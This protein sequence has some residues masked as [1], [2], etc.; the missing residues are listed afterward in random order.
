MKRIIAVL[1]LLASAWAA[2]VAQREVAAAET[3]HTITIDE[4]AWRKWGLQYPATYVFQVSDVP[5]QLAVLRR[6][7]ASQPWI[8]LSSKTGDEFFNG[9]EGVRVDRETKKVYASVG[10]KT[11]NTIELKF[12]GPQSVKF[13]AVAKYYDGRKA[14]YTLS[15]DNWGCNAWGH[16]G[17]PWKGETDDES[18]NYQAALHVCRSFHLP[19]SIAINSRSAGGDACWRLMQE[20]LDRGDASWEPA[21]H[22]WTHPKDAA[23]YAV[24]GYKQETVGCREDILQRLHN[25]PYGPYIV[26]HILTHGYQDDA[27]L[28]NDAGEFLFLRGFN[29]LDNPSSNEYVAW[30][31]QYGF[32]GVGGLNTR[33]YDSLLEKREPKGRYFAADVAHLNQ[34]FDEVLKSG[35][36]FYALWHPDRFQNS[37]LYDRRPGI[38]GQQGSTLIQHLAYVANRKDVWY[39]ANGWLYVYRFVAENA[40]VTPKAAGN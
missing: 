36:V 14:A 23:A 35:G 20:E 8:G 12:V 25:I 34:G 18:D 33:G 2:D 6:D 22:G 3:T 19:L 1:S 39:A 32:Y 29:W 21:V 15:N 5:T 16:P 24:H 13:E 38:E 27:L 31:K 28:A 7:Q 37:I 17:A 9:V 10:F 30:N 4:K 26:E 40:S 11:A